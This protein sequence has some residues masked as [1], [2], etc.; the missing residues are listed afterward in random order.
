MRLIFLLAFLN[1]KSPRGAQ[2]Q[3]FW[4][5]IVVLFLF[6][7]PVLHFTIWGNIIS[8]K[9]VKVCCTRIKYYSQG[10]VL[11][12]CPVRLQ[13]RILS[14]APFFFCCSGKVLSVCLPHII[15]D[16]EGNQE[17]LLSNLQ[18]S[19]ASC[20]INTRRYIHTYISLCRNL[21]SINRTRWNTTLLVHF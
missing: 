15:R 2:W 8:W 1:F 19:P 16:R 3:K 9:Q 14:L 21:P 13:H 11:H 20:K 7:L 6:P 4:I 12:S 17:F 5:H 10:Q 18:P